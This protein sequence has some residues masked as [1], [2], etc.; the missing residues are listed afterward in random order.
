M[1]QPRPKRGEVD[2]VGEAKGGDGRQ[3]RQRPS[4]ATLAVVGPGR[5]GLPYLSRKAFT[6]RAVSATVMS[7][8]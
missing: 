2:K 3:W 4:A 6:N 8:K 1:G 5:L 7:G